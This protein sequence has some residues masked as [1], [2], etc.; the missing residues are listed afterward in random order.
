MS[1]EWLGNLTWPEAAARIRAG[2]VV[3]P[4]MQ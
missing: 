3:L 4:G 1:G 2:T